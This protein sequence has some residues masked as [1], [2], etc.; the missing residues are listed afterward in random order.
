MPIEIDFISRLAT[1][2]VAVFAAIVL[3]MTLS[4]VFYVLPRK[5]SAQARKSYIPRIQFIAEVLVSVGLIGLVSFA[6]KAKFEIDA[7][8]LKKIALQ[9]ERDVA[10]SFYPYAVGECMST[11]QQLIDSPDVSAVLAVCKIWKEF[12]YVHDVQ[13]PWR[14]AS[15]E[16]EV[17]AN[18]DELNPKLRE[19]IKT[20]VNAINRMQDARDNVAVLPLKRDILASGT[21]WLFVLLCAFS[22][23][24]G[25][26][27]KCAR[28]AL[29]LWVRDV[30]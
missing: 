6:G 24:V 20:M 17:V 29:Q 5:L 4:V 8:E 1:P 9:S 10:A 7:V 22:A 13:L 12:N 11:A 28:A 26:A 18:N 2:Q 21:S 16:L 27:L 19:D 25:V 14:E 3:V 23:C 15:R 30:F